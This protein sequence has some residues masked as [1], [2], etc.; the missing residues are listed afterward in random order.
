MPES[1]HPLGKAIEREIS[2]P[3]SL[4]STIKKALAD[5]KDVSEIINVEV[6][7]NRHDNVVV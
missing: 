2:P 6:T 7:Q 5:G 1:T 3:F 4:H